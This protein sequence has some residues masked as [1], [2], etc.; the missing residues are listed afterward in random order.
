VTR[1]DDAASLKVETPIAFVGARVAEKDTRDR[2]GRQFVFG[3][4]GLVGIA[5]ATKDARSDIVWSG[6]V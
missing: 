5:E 3:G 2:P 6:V 1:D 4:G